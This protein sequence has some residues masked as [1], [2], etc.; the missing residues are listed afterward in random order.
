VILTFSAFSY[1][2]TSD[3]RECK[4]Q[5]STVADLVK[6]FINMEMDAKNPKPKATSGRNT[7]VDCK[8]QTEADSRQRDC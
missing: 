6:K 8:I 3:D 4:Q 2:Y 7:K 5:V 1:Y